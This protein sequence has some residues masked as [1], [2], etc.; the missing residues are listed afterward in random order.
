MVKRFSNGAFL[1][2][3]VGNFDDKCVFLTTPDG[4]CKPPKDEEY[5]CDLKTYAD[6]YGVDR[7]YGD[8]LCVYDMVHKDVEEE[9][10]Q[11]I[12]AISSTYAED[13]I[14]IDIM[15]S[16]L[17]MAMIAEEC[18]LYTK[19]GKRIKR[20]GIH[21]LLFENKTVSEAAN[22]MRGMNWRDIDVLCKQRG[23]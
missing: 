5:F 21:M 20:L 23:F 4:K 13:A 11:R 18:K 12:S 16:I 14:N 15:F 3:G 6:K 1:D 9:S 19:L 10:L 17:Y 8:Y 2:Y 7:I 22:C